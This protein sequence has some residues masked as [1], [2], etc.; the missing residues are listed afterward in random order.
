MAGRPRLQSVFEW[1]QTQSEVKAYSDADCAGNN[2]SRKFTSGGCL[3]IGS[4]LIN[5]CSKTQTL[6]ALSSGESEF[7][8]TL[9]IAAEILG[10]MPMAKDFGYTLHGR[11]WGDA[12]AALGA[13][14]RKGLGT[15]RHIDTSY[16]WIQ[17]VAAQC[18]FDFAKV[19]GKEGP[20]DLYTKHLDVAATDKHVSKL[21]CRYAGV[22]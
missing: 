5:G 15:T 6:I 17:Q 16:L 22:A 18:R 19:L 12:S 1:Q 20:A 14:H 3:T 2:E 11:V 10:L 8:A 9:R 21:T 7:Y 13:I 4:H